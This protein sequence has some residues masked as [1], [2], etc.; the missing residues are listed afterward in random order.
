MINCLEIYPNPTSIGGLARTPQMCRYSVYIHSIHPKTKARGCFDSAVDTRVPNAIK[1]NT[2]LENKSFFIMQH[3]IV[4]SKNVLKNKTMF[5]L[6]C[7][8]VEERIFL[9]KHCAG[10]RI[11][12][13]WT[14]SVKCIYNAVNLC[15]RK[16]FSYTE[17]LNRSMCIMKC[18]IGL[19]FY[20]IWREIYLDLLIIL[21]PLYSFSRFA[22]TYYY[23]FDVLSQI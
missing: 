23:Q 2:I 13:F 15:F 21:N 8:I 9:H 18:L 12:Q 14:N 17:M 11:L 10:N 22:S 1:K 20:T 16:Y 3:L 19:K 5:T 6:L 7:K 4:V